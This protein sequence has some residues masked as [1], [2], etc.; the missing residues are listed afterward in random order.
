[1]K[2][3]QMETDG[4]FKNML[5]K[6]VMFSEIATVFNFAQAENEYFG[7]LTSGGKVFTCNSAEA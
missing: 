3:D 6:C 1:M 7:I 2:I 5:F 4:I